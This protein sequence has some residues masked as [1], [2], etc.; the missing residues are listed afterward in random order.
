V[1]TIDPQQL[2]VA[3]AY[4]EDDGAPKVVAKGRGL[5]A[6]AILERAREAGVYV[7]ESAELVALL[8]QVDVDSR[9]PPQ[10]YVAVAELLAWLYRIERGDTLA[11]LPI[12]NPKP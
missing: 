6:Q 8:M 1:A 10:L 3:L 5:L 4:R 7:H 11:P 2:A 9:I 12:A